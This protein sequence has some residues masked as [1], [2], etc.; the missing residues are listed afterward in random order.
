MASVCSDRMDAEGE[1]FN[2]IINELDGILLIMTRIDFQGPDPCGIIN[3][4]VLKASNS[5]PLKVPE[6]D[7]FDVD[8]D[9]MARDFLGITASVNSPACRIL[10]QA[11]HAVSNKGPVNG[12]F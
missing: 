6:R 7:E 2:H 4:R 5:V 8:L 9:V 10:R 12:G 11:S 3:G 1:F